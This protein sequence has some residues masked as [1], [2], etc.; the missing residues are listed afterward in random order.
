M[1][2]LYLL[3]SLS[4]NSPAGSFAAVTPPMYKAGSIQGLENER[5]YK[6]V[7][8]DYFGRLIDAAQKHSRY[9]IFN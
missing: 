5:N 7:S 8:T 4:L 1:R 6:V 9:E 2:C 3:L